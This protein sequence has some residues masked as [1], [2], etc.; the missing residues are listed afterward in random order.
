MLQAAAVERDQ[1]GFYEL[2]SYE[3]CCKRIACSTR[4]SSRK[5]VGGQPSGNMGQLTLRD[6][7]RVSLVTDAFRPVPAQAFS[8]ITANKMTAILIVNLLCRQK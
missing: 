3:Q 5:L 7:R 6:L 8:I 1:T 2:L 4:A